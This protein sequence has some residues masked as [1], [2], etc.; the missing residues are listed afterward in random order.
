MFDC[1]AGKILHVDLSNGEIWSVPLSENWVRNYIGGE[2]FG[3]IYLARI[4]NLF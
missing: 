1:Y 4:P 3:A 2:G